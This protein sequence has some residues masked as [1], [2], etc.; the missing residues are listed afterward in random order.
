MGHSIAQSCLT[1]LYKC[2]YL[3]INSMKIRN[4]A[5]VK[6]WPSGAECKGQAEG[7]VST[8]RSSYVHSALQPELQ[9]RPFAK[10][11]HCDWDLAPET[12]TVHRLLTDCQRPTSTYTQTPEF[13]AHCS[14]I[15]NIGI[16]KRPTSIIIIQHH[17]FNL[18]HY[19]R[20]KEN[21]K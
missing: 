8:E 15:M 10:P 1:V 5:N 17:Q 7:Q 16:T 19:K 2:S 14:G 9:Q 21:K 3:L 12:C 11:S 4:P 6:W 13:T 20:L 18:C